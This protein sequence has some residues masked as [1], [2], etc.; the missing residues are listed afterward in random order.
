MGGWTYMEERFVVLFDLLGHWNGLCLKRFAV[1]FD[2]L[3][4]VC[5][6]L[7][8]LARRHATTC[9]VLR[10]PLALHCRALH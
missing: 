6:A 9:V 7:S 10:V 2:S 8:A 5:G 4:V 3:R 1:L